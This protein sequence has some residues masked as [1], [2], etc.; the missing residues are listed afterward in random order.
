MQRSPFN[1]FSL[2]PG[3]GGV[4][5]TQGNFLVLNGVITLSS[6]IAFPI[7]KNED[8]LIYFPH[9]L[10]HLRYIFILGGITIV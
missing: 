8:Q 9:Q 5:G 2:E 1:N 3:C 10:V 7:E 6:N 4:E